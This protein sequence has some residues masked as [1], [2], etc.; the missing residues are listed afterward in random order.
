M[1]LLAF[2]C[3]AAAAPVKLLVAHA[4]IAIPAGVTARAFNKPFN[5]LKR[6]PSTSRAIACFIDRSSP[7]LWRQLYGV[8]RFRFRIRSN[9]RAVNR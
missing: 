4:A 3:S 6:Q 7:L 5:G 9:R 1:T 8:S 2:D